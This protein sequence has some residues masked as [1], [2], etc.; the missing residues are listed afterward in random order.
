MCFEVIL[1][2]LICGIDLLKTGSTEWQISFRETKNGHAVPNMVNM[3]DLHLWSSI[4]S[5]F[6]FSLN[7]FSVPP[8]ELTHDK[9]NHEDRKQTMTMKLKKFTKFK[10]MTSKFYIAIFFKFL[11][12]SV[13]GK[14]EGHLEQGNLHRYFDRP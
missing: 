8:P 2:T 4:W 10:W 11:M 3:E 1:G 7:F 9:L 5:L 6:R 12:F 13:A 14:N